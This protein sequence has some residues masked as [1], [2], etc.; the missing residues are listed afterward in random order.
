M[1]AFLD[2]SKVAV[3]D[4]PNTIWIKRRMD[5]GTKCRVEDMLTRMAISGTGSRTG[6]I[7]FTLGAQ[8]L[9][10]AV[11]NIVAWE[12]PE[13]NGVPCDQ[14]HI[15]KLDPEYPVFKAALDKITELNQPREDTPDPL[16]FTTDTVKLTQANGTAAPVATTST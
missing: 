14:D 10:L 11:H 5:F 12:G 3:R 16:P 2:T 9:A 13:F 6:E 1:G 7:Q 8:R 15:E 4:G